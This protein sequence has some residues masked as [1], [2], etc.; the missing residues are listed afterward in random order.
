MSASVKIDNNDHTYTETFTYR[1][2]VISQDGG[3]TGE[4][5]LDIHKRLNKAGNNVISIHA[6]W[7]SA[8]HSTVHGQTYQS[9]QH[10]L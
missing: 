6:V 5:D 8:Q 7:N 10:C 2:S 3:L 1:E 9:C 4:A